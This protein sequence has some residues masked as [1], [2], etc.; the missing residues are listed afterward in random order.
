MQAA[1]KF[2]PELARYASDRGTRVMLEPLHPI[3]MNTD[4]FISTLNEAS[5]MIDD[6]NHDNFGVAIDT[7]HVFAEV[8]LPKRLAALGR[9]IFAVH[10]SDWPGE[11]PR[12]RGDWLLPGDGCIDLPAMLGGIEASGYRG[13]YSLEIFSSDE[14]SDS[15]WKTDPA[16]RLNGVMRVL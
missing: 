15:L 14:L 10:I 16:A 9:R 5:R 4:T 6:V 13:A 7:I 3:F 12:W 11:H 1:R 2:Y 8:D